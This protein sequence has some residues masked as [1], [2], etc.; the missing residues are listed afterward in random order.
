MGIQI[1]RDDQ[2]RS[3]IK[4]NAAIRK[5]VT[6]H[7]E[8]LRL[9]YVSVPQIVGITGA[10]ENIDTLF[11]VGNRLDLPLFFSQ[12]GQL[13]LEQALQ[14][15]T[16]AY[17]IIHSGRD[18][19]EEDERHLRE[20]GLTEE[21]FDCTTVGMSEQNY[22][23]EKMFE[24]LLAHIE[25]AIKSMIAATIEECPN[26]LAAFGQDIDYLKR[27]HE[28][29]FNRI[30]YEDVISLL[31]ENGFPEL[32]FGDDLKARHEQRVVELMTERST[33]HEVDREKGIPCFITRYPYPIKF[34]NMK[35]SM[36]DSRVVL[37]ADLILPK[38]GESVGAAVR[39]HDGVKLKDALINSVMFALHKKR[40]GTF[41]DFAWYVD[42]LVGAGKTKPHAGYGIGNER[43]MQFLL[44]QSDIRECSLF[45]LMSR[46]S[47]DWDPA[48][49]G[50][51]FF[52]TPAKKKVL[53]SIGGIFN[54]EELLSGLQ[55][56]AKSGNER[57]VFYATE[58]TH[59]FLSQQGIK[60]TLVHKISDPA[61]EPNIGQLLKDGFFDVIVNLPT[62][63]DNPRGE[64]TDGRMIR[65]AALKTGTA[66]I[67]DLEV[68]RDF[69]NDVSAFYAA[70][71]S[72][73]KE[74]KPAS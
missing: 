37:S 6:R 22:D 23:D 69:F 5:G 50:K 14:F 64:L 42:G 43:V 55:S 26:E 39:E 38:S 61:S 52:F 20:F 56:A 31:N 58:K 8:A 10:C 46:D 35:R 2:M 25:M 16:G 51:Y 29:R 60:S 9:Q 13:A 54:K 28:T 41:S 27:V 12:T 11:R 66:L 7:Y 68:A 59:T 33:S 15:S 3:L 19:E 24:H 74:L 36:K 73:P 67:T 65:R 40:G 63:L 34:F 32:K 48:R 18:E 62:P 49:R 71:G 21:E 53:L 4:V 47:G 72:N 57:L 44:G 1:S 70:E 45:S 30:S 17:T